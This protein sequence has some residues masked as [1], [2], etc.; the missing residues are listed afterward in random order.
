L[1]VRKSV[2]DVVL[3]SELRR[4][5]IA[6]SLL[7]QLLC[8]WNKIQSRA[9][10]DLVKMAMQES[11]ALA[12]R[13]LRDC[14]VGHLAKCLG[15]FGVD[16]FG[17]SDFILDVNEVL[18]V[19]HAQW[20]ARMLGRLQPEDGVRGM[21]RSRSDDARVGFKTLTYFRWFADGEC[22]I[23]STFWY[24]LNRPEQITTIARFRM[25]C[26]WLNIE[27]DRIAKTYTPRSLR[28]CR[29]CDMGVREDEMHVL[30]CPLYQDL[31]CAHGVLSYNGVGGNED[32]VMQEHMNGSDNAVAFWNCMASF[33][34]RCKFKREQFIII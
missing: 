3:M 18:D 25:G 4:K 29:C 27:N 20:Q 13:G 5:P 6:I 32:A 1:G 8:F 7:K 17:R 23:K 2:P 26:H 12:N 21:V 16:L 11:Y 30:E 22:D 34:I 33:L 9:D 10:D 24:A 19:V 31:R 15:K 14:W 28:L